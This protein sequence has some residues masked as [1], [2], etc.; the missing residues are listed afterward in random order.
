MWEVEVPRIPPKLG[1]LIPFDELQRSEELWVPSKA[2]R[3]RKTF[4]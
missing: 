3:E 4:P 2:K 1:W